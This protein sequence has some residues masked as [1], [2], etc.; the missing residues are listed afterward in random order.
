MESRGMS[1]PAFGIQLEG[2]NEILL[3]EAVK[4][5]TEARYL[6]RM[7]GTTGAERTDVIKRAEDWLKKYY[8]NYVI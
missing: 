7:I 1:D 4:A 3:G 6:I 5:M 8:P 2:G